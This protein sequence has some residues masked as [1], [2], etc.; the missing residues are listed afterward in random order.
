M[1]IRIKRLSFS[2][3]SVHF[4]ETCLMYRRFIV[5]LNHGCGRT[6]VLSTKQMLYNKTEIWLR[7]KVLCFLVLDGWLEEGFGLIIYVKCEKPLPSGI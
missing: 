7:W 3:W 4:A 1:I 6:E 2:W 5:Y